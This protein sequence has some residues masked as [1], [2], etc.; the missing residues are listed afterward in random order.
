MTQH[1]LDY[2]K[3]RGII[4]THQANTPE[5]HR[6]RQRLYER[7]GLVPN[8]FRGARVVEFGPGSCDN[9]RVVAGWKPELLYLVDA[10]PASIKAAT[11]LADERPG[12]VNFQQNEILNTSNSGGGNFDIVLCE[13]V[14][15]GQPEP[16]AVLD[17]ISRFVAADGV[18]VITCQSP[19]GLLAEVCRRLLMGVFVERFGPDQIEDRMLAFFE[20]DLDELAK[21]GMSRYRRDWIQDQI[22]CPWPNPVFTVPEATEVLRSKFDIL[23]TAS[24]TFNRDFRWYKTPGD[25]YTTLLI[26]YYGSI[27]MFLDIRIEHPSRLE[28][29]L[30]P[31]AGKYLEDLARHLVELHESARKKPQK[32]APLFLEK[33]DDFK[34]VIGLAH[35]WPTCEAIDDFINGARRLLNNQ[36]G[37]FNLFRSWFGRGQQYISFI[38]RE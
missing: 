29:I 18:L 26:E 10:N 1:P 33:L 17:H 37:E 21:L 31:Q 35:H 16:K 4:P 14:I 3:E 30:S 11:K 28:P 27:S 36:D 38:K 2:Y 22:L 5:L 8:A 19:I 32:C 6:R 20:P 13:G 23:G 34:N 7:L 12:M 15:P 9:A 25:R 24:P